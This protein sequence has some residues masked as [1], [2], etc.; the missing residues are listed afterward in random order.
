MNSRKQVL[1]YAMTFADV[2]IDTPFRDSNW[3]LARHK[4]NKKAFA[5]TYE[6]DGFMWVNV[7]TDPMWR[8]LYRS[9]YNAVIAGYH[10]NKEH[11]NS[12]RLDD[13]IPDEE[14][15]RMIAQSYDL[16]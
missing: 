10:Q 13:T 8:D 5:W 15:K 6:K 2:Y 3:V 7:K 14:V 16:T 9:A 4:K 11:W 12:I 1:D